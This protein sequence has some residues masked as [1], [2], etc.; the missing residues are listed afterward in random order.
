[1]ADTPKGQARLEGAYR[2][3]TP[4][5]NIE[6]YRDFAAT[7]DTE[8]AEGLG[9]TYPARVAAVFRNLAGEKDVPIADIG[10]GTG[11]VAAAL[12]DVIVDGMDISP[13]ML[14]RSQERGCYRT[15]YEVDLTAASLPLPR[16]YG[17]VIS[18]GTFTHGH[19]GPDVLVGLLDLAR[20]GA[21]FVIGINA[22]HY[23]TH[24]FEECLSQLVQDGRISAPDLQD[25][26][27]YEKDGHDH[28]GDRAL[29]TS[30]RKK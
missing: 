1:M 7:Y 5:D 14:I 15:L 25:V 6:Y 16:D 11:L 26:P 8:F 21:L 4:A 9:Y 18:A 19:L 13:E 2:L 28:A 29:I 10:C 12:G 22:E 27:I 3:A 24:G 30:F 23:G 20:E 17:G